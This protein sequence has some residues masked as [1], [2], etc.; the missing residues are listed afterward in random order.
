MRFAS[1]SMLWCGLQLLLPALSRHQHS[2]LISHRLWLLACLNQYSTGCLQ[3]VTHC[4]CHDRG[5]S[6]LFWIVNQTATAFKSQPH[7]NRALVVRSDLRDQLAE[8]ELHVYCT[9]KRILARK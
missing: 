2:T 4:T 1:E 3:H 6:T 5:I 8:A 9:S 7:D